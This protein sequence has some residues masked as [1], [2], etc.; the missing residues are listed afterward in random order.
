MHSSAVRLIKDRGDVATVTPCSGRRIRK[1]HRFIVSF[2]SPISTTVGT[3]DNF[4][5]RGLA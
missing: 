4:N 5:V 3:R 2:H 1:T